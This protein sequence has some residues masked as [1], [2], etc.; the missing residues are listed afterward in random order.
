MTIKTLTVAAAV[1]AITAFAFG[2]GTASA[3]PTATV[4]ANGSVITGKV[5]GATGWLGCSMLEAKTANPSLTVPLAPS[6]WT[7]LAD[8]APDGSGNATLASAPV[9]NGQHRVYLVCVEDPNWTH[10][11]WLVKDKVV[12]TPAASSSIDLG[13][14][15]L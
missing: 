3:A 4:V 1:G 11:E 2:T 13:S 9:T 7:S 12:T 8:E 6:D 5:I 15:Q 10:I 14:L